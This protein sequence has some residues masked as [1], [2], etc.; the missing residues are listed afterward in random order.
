MSL[1]SQIEVLNRLAG[2]VMP[3]MF[4]Q[5][6]VLEEAEKLCSEREVRREDYRLDWAGE[7]LDASSARRQVEKLDASFTARHNFLENQVRPSVLFAPL[8]SIDD[9]SEAEQCDSRAD[10]GVRHYVPSV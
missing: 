2:D 3:S 8:M 4:D 5:L 6:S 1:Q 10:R 9:D 7:V